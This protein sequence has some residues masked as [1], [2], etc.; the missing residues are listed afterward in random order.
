M[1]YSF[2]QETCHI[3]IDVEKVK[4]LADMEGVMNLCFSES[5]KKWFSKLSPDKKEE[6]FYKIWTAKE[7]YIKAIGKG[8]SFSP[9]RISLGRRNRR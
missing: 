8:F 6:I 7:A 1:Q 2:S 5:E 4:E 9:N 3:G